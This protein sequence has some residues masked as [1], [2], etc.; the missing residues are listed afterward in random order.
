MVD[1]RDAEVVDV[2][3]AQ[4]RIMLIAVIILEVIII[5][6]VIVAMILDI[7]DAPPAV[8][9]VPVP[10][11]AVVEVVEINAI[12]HCKIGYYTST[13]FPLLSPKSLPHFAMAFKAG[14]R[15]FPNSV[16]EYSTRIGGLV[17]NTFRLINP[18][19]SSFFN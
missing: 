10:A 15:V 19:S 14:I 12:R 4:V 7:A 1:V 3:I 17:P 16:S 13:T 9:A 5:I 11:A 18:L 2:P 8:L 6:P